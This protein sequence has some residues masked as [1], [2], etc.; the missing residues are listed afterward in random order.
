MLGMTPDFD[1]LWNFG[2]PADSEGRF[3]EAMAKATGERRDELRTQV[4]RA[5]GL[6]GQFDQ[7]HAELDQ[8]VEPSGRVAVHAA[9]ERGRLFNSAGDP[10]RG[11]AQFRRAV[12]LATGCGEVGLEIDALH[13]LGIAAPESE[14]IGWNERAI[15]RAE[16]SDD[17]RAVRWLGSLLNNTAWSYHEEGLFERALGLFVR[18]EAWYQQFGTPETQQ[19]A[20]WSIGRCLRSLGRFEEALRIQQSLA[21]EIGDEWPDGF[22]LEEIAEIL[23]QQGRA[24]EAAHWFA[25]AADILGSDPWLADQ[26]PDRLARLRELGQR[27]G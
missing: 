11:V 13:M 1:H 3:R 5:L 18:A 8:I 20:Q 22:V 7:G 17:P 16:N 6:Q 23:Y 9:L 14:R 19:I 10:L 15:A 25:R 24:D 4:A 26:E 12:E 21:I 2:D 27:A